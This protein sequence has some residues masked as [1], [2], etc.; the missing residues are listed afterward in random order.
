MA[1]DP[2]SPDGLPVDGVDPAGWL[3]SLLD[4]LTMSERMGDLPSPLGF[5]GTLRPYQLR[6]V[7]W[8]WFL[9]RLGLGACLADDMGLG[10]T[11][12]TIAWLLHGREQAAGHRPALVDLS[13][14]CRRKLAA[15]DCAVCAGLDGPDPSRRRSAGRRRLP[16]GCQRLRCGDQ[17]LRP[18][19][20]GCWHAEPGIVVCG[21]R[22]RGAE[23]QEPRDQAGPGDAQAA[24]RAPRRTYGHAGG[25]PAER[26]V[27]YHAV[28]QSGLLELAAQLPTAVRVAGRALR[29]YRSLGP[30][31][32]PGAAV[33]LASPQD[34]SERHPGPA[35]KERD[36]GLLSAHPG[37]G[38][39]IRGS[40]AGYASTGRDGRGDRASGGWC[41]PCS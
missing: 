9:R 21:D 14:L 25:E 38:H 39:A 12:Q 6:G 31:A 35:R 24:G 40:S 30:A 20:P 4:E 2:L 1:L 22:R 19:A 27:V 15:R 7:A 26:P 29:R 3:R 11:P 10:K 5:Q 41:S 13:D 8:L 33:R 23:H 18:G 37:A 34:R 17:Q 16:P 36:E 32:A 28:P